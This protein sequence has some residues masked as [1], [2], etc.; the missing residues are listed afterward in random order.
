MTDNASGQVLAWTNAKAETTTSAYNTNGYLQSVTGPIS[1]ANTTFAYDSYGR[2]RRTTAS[3]GYATTTD[4]DALDRPTRVTY[5]DGTYDS[6]VYS[7]LDVDQQRD[8]LGRITRLFYDPV[9]HLTA[10]RDPL[11]RT[12]TQQWCTCGSLEALVDAKGQATSWER[13]IQDRVTREVRADGTTATVYSYET[14]TSRPK[15][16]TDPKGQVQT[17]TYAL[18]DAL[19]VTVYSNAEHATPTVSFTYDASYPRVTTTVDGTG[20]TTYTYKAAGT[21]GA[22]QVASVDGPLTNDTITYDYDELGRPTG[23]AINSVGLTETYDALGRLTGEVNPLG[24]FGYTYVGATGRVDTTTYPNGQTTSYSYFG[25]SGD[26]RLQTQRH[27]AV[28]YRAT[29]TRDRGLANEFGRYGPANRLRLERIRMRRGRAAAR[30]R[31]ILQRV[32]TRFAR[33]CLAG[34]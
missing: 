32:T 22:T 24:T 10:T 3:D 29:A 7:R 6:V 20:T 31:R 8:R 33:T 12:V 28:E 26:R 23:R 1:G 34:E 11:G 4:Y 19:T 16:V 13:D 21:P 27:A 2:R 15:T 25:N 14:T 30:E 17:H 5:P 9:R 18:D